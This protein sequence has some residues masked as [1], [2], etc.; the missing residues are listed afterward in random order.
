[1][2]D[3]LAR[4]ITDRR[5]EVDKQLAGPALRRARPERVAKEV[6]LHVLM[7]ALLAG[8]LFARKDTLA[9]AE[10]LEPVWATSGPDRDHGAGLAIEYVLGI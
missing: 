1:V 8:V 6:K 2:A 10:P 3:G 7:R 5:S 9:H 4:L